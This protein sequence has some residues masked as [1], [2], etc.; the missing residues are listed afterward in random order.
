[1]DPQKTQLNSWEQLVNSPVFFF[2]SLNL[3]SEVSEFKPGPFQIYIVDTWYEGP[4]L[5]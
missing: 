2:F 4:T 1:M 5:M 3:V